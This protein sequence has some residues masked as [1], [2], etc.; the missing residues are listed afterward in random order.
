MWLVLV[1]GILHHIRAVLLEYG[2]PHLVHLVHIVGL[3]QGIDGSGKASHGHIAV[4]QRLHGHVDAQRHRG[5]LGQASSQDIDNLLAH[6]VRPEELLEI[7]RVHLHYLLVTHGDRSAA[8]L[9]LGGTS[10]TSLLLLLSVSLDTQQRA[11]GD[12]VVAAVLL[13][14]LQ[15]CTCFGTFLDFVKDDAGLARN[16]LGI[17]YLGRQEHDDVVHILGTVESRLPLLLLEEV[18]IDNVLV[19][20]AGKLLRYKGLSALANAHNNERHTVRFSLP[21]YQYI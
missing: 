13:E 11:G 6:V 4:Q 12:D 8:L 1:F 16:E 5:L 9:L 20:L 7:E 2:M 15:A 19:V 10:F 14:K 18:D 3:K 21:A 17:T